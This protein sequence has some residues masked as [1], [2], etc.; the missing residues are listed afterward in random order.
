[1]VTDEDT[2]YSLELLQRQAQTFRELHRDLS[3]KLWSL[4]TESGLSADFFAETLTANSKNLDAIQARTDELE[5]LKASA[6]DS[7]TSAKGA[8]DT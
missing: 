2:G 6:A 4:T 8:D 5:A 7:T 1:M 3:D